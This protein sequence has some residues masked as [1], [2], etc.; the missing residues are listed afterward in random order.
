MRA[1]RELALLQNNM[2]KY[3]HTRPIQNKSHL[4]WGQNRL[5]LKYEKHISLRNFC[6]E[7]NLTGNS[8]EIDR[9]WS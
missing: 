1:K 7:N 4:K 6:S 8:E 5:T 2:K 9:I 3:L